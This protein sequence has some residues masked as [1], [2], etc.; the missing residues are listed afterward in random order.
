[1][2]RRTFLTS[3]LAGLGLTLVGGR[4]TRAAAG[5]NRLVLIMLRGGADALSLVSPA[6]AAAATLARWRP[7]LALASGIALSPD[8][9]AHPALAPLVTSASLANLTLVLHTGGTSDSRSHFDQQYRIE[10]GDASGAATRGFL[11]NAALT[12]NLRTCAVQRTAPRSLFGANP[13]VLSDPAR[14]AVGY[15]DTGIKPGWSR[16]QRLAMYQTAAGEVGDPKVDALS[17]QA[18]AEGDLL[19]AELGAETLATLTSRH[20]YV[21]TSAFAGRLA[22][23][24]RLAATSLAPSLLTV[25]GGQPWDTHS[26]QATN[27]ASSTTGV[28]ASAND[29]ATNLA[30]FRTD[31][32][33]RGLWGSTVVVVMSEFG[34]TV[35]E[36]SNIGTDHGRG[37]L[38]IVM[39]G[40]VR[41]F[42]SPG[43]LGVPQ[44]QLP[45][46]VD[47]ST[48]LALL[49]DYR[50]VMA[51]LL[52]RHLLLPAATVQ[53]AFWGQLGA[54]PSYLNVLA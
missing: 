12:A 26:S 6:G 50:V 15:S 37:G 4:A 17:R 18:L 2:Q 22:L 7:N 34:R 44:W 38:M 47:S 25:D 46:T 11:A 32:I 24:A 39:G 19:A 31:L 41:A 49:H 1:M 8:L 52:E 3:T 42:G 45:S 40:R 43:Y 16:A 14:L 5:N 13:I 21:P 10:T 9:Q 29:L 54:N 30:A 48:A 33:A 20:G 35:K 23:T 53:A 51:E 28:Y 27:D 36:N